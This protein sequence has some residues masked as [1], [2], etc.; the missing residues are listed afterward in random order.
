MFSCNPLKWSYG[1]NRHFQQYFSYIP[2]CRFYCW[3]KP[4]KNTDLQASRW[5]TL[6]HKVVCCIEYTS[7][8]ELATL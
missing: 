1:G 2:G 3:R 6:S 5:Q 4:E 7:G 8:L